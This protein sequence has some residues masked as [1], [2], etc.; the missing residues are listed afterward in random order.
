[1]VNQITPH[2]EPAWSY[3]DPRYLANYLIDE[4]EYFAFQIRTLVSRLDNLEQGLVKLRAM[5]HNTL[6]NVMIDFISSWDG[7]IFTAQDIFKTVGINSPRTKNKVHSYL[8]IFV[9]QG[10]AYKG[11]GR[12]EYLKNPPI[13]S[14]IL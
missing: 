5:R 8:S 9:R 4:L 14:G 3:D 10:R 1:M 11:K 13:P 12:G 2:Q 6:V 7:N